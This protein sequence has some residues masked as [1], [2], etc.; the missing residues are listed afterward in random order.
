[1]NMI[2]IKRVNDSVKITENFKA[3]E[4][5]CNH[6]DDVLID[7]DLVD[8]LEIFRT[9]IGK[10]PIIITSG[11]RCPAH[12]RVV[13][14]ASSSLHLKGRAVDLVLLSQFNA[15]DVFNIAVGIFN[16]VGLYQSSVNPKNAYM[17]VD[18]G[19]K[20]TYWLSF[21]IISAGKT[22]RTY[23]Y[24]KNIQN[25]RDYMKTDKTRPWFEMVI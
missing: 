12:N 6:C 9:A 22:K 23:V 8:Q 20:G 2:N 1:M 11:Y 14:G 16:R 25:L 5:K 3:K 15:V 13:G 24:F 17:H 7:K 19:E 10:K 21:P 4:F 18:N